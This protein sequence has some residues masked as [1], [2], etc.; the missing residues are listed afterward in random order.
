M[1]ELGLDPAA[2]GVPGLCRVIQTARDMSPKMYTPR[3]LQRSVAGFFA[4][5]CLLLMVEGQ[6]MA[7]EKPLNGESLKG[8]GKSLFPAGYLDHKGLSAALRKVVDSNPERVKLS[9][10][11]TS[12]EG[13]EVWLVTL[14]TPAQKGKP[15]PSILLVA[16]LE[17]DHLVGSQVALDLLN[18]LTDPKAD[19]SWLDRVTMYIIPRLNPDGAEKAL[20]PKPAA[21]FRTN[22][23]PI[24]RDRDGKYGED[25]PDDLDGDG[26]VTR[27]RLKDARTATLVP[28]E[29]D[30]RILRKAD[31]AK[32]ERAVYSEEAEGHDDD[33]DGLR[34]ED[35]PGGVNLNRNWPYK[36]AEFDRE[37]G[38]SPTSEP[39]T[40]ALIKFAFDHPEIVAVWSFGLNDNLR[41]EPKKPASSLDDADLPI[42]AELTRVFAKAV[43]PYP[44]GETPP[45]ATTDGAF[46]EWGYHQL[47]VV[48]LASR[49]FTA[50]E[51]PAP[52]IPE[53]T[54][55]NGAAKADEKAPKTDVAKSEKAK[56][57]SGP[58]ESTIKGQGAEKPAPTP[59]PDGGEARWLYWNDAIVGGHAFVPF[60]PFEHP[61][62]GKVEI[63]GWRPGVRLNPPVEQVGPISEKHFAFLKEL[64]TRLPR[65]VV[66]EAKSVNKGAGLFEITASVVNEGYLPTAMTVG[67]KNRKTPPVLV[68]FDPGKARLL[69][70]QRLERV[71]SLPGSGGRKALRW[72]VEAPDAADAVRIEVSSPK[73]GSD[74]A[75][76]PLRSR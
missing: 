34:N 32:G 39:E 21:E 66:A 2:Q 67:V 73:A 11:A 76:V 57:A 8:N 47:G 71:D 49:L 24:D 46:S 44:K 51:I 68:R 50:P 72:L 16:N 29:K 53:G 6:A 33:G 15:K 59:I 61:T 12:G 10:L 35:A 60:H 36:W 14:G 70:G 19:P 17:A 28:D 31:A 5:S 56:E 20:A 22:L 63:G 65:I 13:R 58:K 74:S 7:Q 23:R 75:S 42:L 1:S 54:K 4:F 55:E 52:S 27:M 9:S 62:L 38:F 69:A 45:G 40:F 37:S 25:G 18:R 26:A 43:G 41:E 30:P 64:A 3:L 48:G